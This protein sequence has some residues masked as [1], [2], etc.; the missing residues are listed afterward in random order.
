MTIRLSMAGRPN[1]VADATKQ[2]YSRH[3]A[4]QSLHVNIRSSSATG[5]PDCKLAPEVR[6]KLQETLKLIGGEIGA[7]LGD[8]STTITPDILKQIRLK[9]NNKGYFVCAKNGSCRVKIANPSGDVKD[10][11]RL[12]IENK[13]KVSDETGESASSIDVA[14]CTSTSSSELSF[15]SSV[16]QRSEL[17]KSNSADDREE[18]EL[19]LQSGRD[20]SVITSQGDKEHI[21]FLRQG[22]ANTDNRRGQLQLTGNDYV[23]RQLFRLYYQ[24]MNRVV[25]KSPM[26]FLDDVRSI[27]NYMTRDNSDRIHEI[28]D[29]SSAST[30][31]NN[32]PS[33]QVQ[34]E[35]I[36]EDFRSLASKAVMS[37]GSGVSTAVSE[38]DSQQ[39]DTL[40]ELETQMKLATT[41]LQYLGHDPELFL[42][43]IAAMQYV[44]DHLTRFSPIIA[45][46][47]D[48]L[49]TQPN[50]SEVEWENLRDNLK[51]FSSEHSSAAIDPK[52]CLTEDAYKKLEE[53][54]KLLKEQC[55]LLEHTHRQIS[56]IS[57][58]EKDSTVILASLKLCIQD[59][60]APKQA[61]KV[62]E[63]A[64]V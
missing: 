61:N 63:V 51:Y 56:V 41:L 58:Q 40:S 26:Y 22:T 6:G 28:T 49:L 47:S 59:V 30:E 25:T 50:L 60:L 1:N 4:D 36:I 5:A 42:K 3:S 46:L 34:Q 27:A 39:K 17:S 20:S 11:W 62:E 9:R 53:Q 38:H 15:G 54:C 10:L 57:Q 43:Y 29:D 13:T 35:Q 14:S 21:R 23:F 32:P 24:P 16:P 2:T 8:V 48:K 64:N 45:A 44:M 52:L 33:K 55:P 31:V 37:L 7:A 19:V 12:L 18:C